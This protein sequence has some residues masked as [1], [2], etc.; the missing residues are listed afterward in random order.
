MRK[1]RAFAALVAVLCAFGAGSPAPAGEKDAK[2]RSREDLVL[3]QLEELRKEV[4]DLRISTAGAR[5]DLKDLSDRL[6]AIERRLD[7]L[8]TPSTSSRPAFSFD[9][10]QQLATGTIRLDN[11][12]GVRAHVTIDGV[13]YTVPPHSVQ[14]LRNQP[15]RRL[16]YYW[17]AD[18]YGTSPQLTTTLAPRERWTLTIY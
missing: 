15:A 13:I 3:R 8:A 1:L 2:E 10:A 5:L 12:L 7:R 4:A 18:G 11:R 9:P 14:E 16:N 17:T 6:A